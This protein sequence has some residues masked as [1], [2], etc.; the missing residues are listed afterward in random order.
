[1]TIEFKPWPK[2]PRA[3]G[4]SVTI[5]EKLDGTNSCIV[6]QD[7]LIVGIQSRNRFITVSDDNYGFANWVSDNEAELLGLGD[8]YHYGEWAGAG[9]QKNPHNMVGKKFFL[10]NTFRWN[11]DNPNLP[12]CCNVVPV[13]FQGEMEEKEIDRVLFKLKEISLSEGYV[14]EGIVV[15][16][17][18]TKRYEKYTYNYVAGKWCK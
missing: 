2:I 16:Y 12:G 6:I 9:I 5:T 10:F 11:K 13:L 15:Y 17:Q 14:A 4:E 7:G 18:K 8:G 1:M 3:T